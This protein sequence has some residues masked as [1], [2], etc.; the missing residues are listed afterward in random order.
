MACE[1]FKREI[2]NVLKEGYFGDKNDFV[3]VSDGYDDLVHVV[4]VSRKFNWGQ[5]DDKKRR[6]HRAR[7]FIKHF[8]DGEWGYV[9]LTVGR[10]PEEVRLWWKE[11]AAPG[12]YAPAKGVRE[13]IDAAF[14]AGCF[15]DADVFVDA[16]YAKDGKLHIVVI[17]REFASDDSDV[18]ARYARVW[19]VLSK[20]LTSAELARVVRLVCVNPETIKRL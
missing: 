2:Y 4:V 18:E 5:H 13:R 12:R 3:D 7:T 20:G 1:T 10:L 9:S 19:E 14:D 8:P 17:S 11:P 16:A 15:G 6:H